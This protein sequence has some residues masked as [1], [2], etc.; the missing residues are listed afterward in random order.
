MFELRSKNTAKIKKVFYLVLL[1]KTLYTSSIMKY[2]KGFALVTVLL[3]ILGISAVGAVAYFAGK[4]STPKNEVVD[5]LNYQ[6][7][8][9]QNQN[10]NTNSNTPVKNPPTQDSTKATLIIKKDSIPNHSQDFNFLVKGI[11]SEPGVSNYSLNFILDDDQAGAT[12][13]TKFLQLIPGTYAVS[14][15]E[16]VNWTTKWSCTP[17][18]EGGT[19]SGVG[20][21]VGVDIGAGKTVTC[22][23]TN[24]NRPQISTTLP[25]YVGTHADCGGP[26]QCWPPVITTSSQSYSCNNIGVAPNT[27]GNDVTAQRII[28][29]KTYCIRSVSSG[30]AGGRGYTYTYTTSHTSGTKIATFGLLFPSC[31]N[32]DDPMRAQCTSDQ[33]T[34]KNNLDALIDSLM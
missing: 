24:T 31:G 21:S 8:V 29:G 1:Q 26:S 23:F 14:E 28:N 4:A 12:S 15:T 33:T 22:T 25:Q 34:F 19:D 32:L 17:G 6:P 18:F 27:E 5:N 10:N 13:N 2:N 9:T 7:P 20:N 11:S 16:T 30:Y 3:I